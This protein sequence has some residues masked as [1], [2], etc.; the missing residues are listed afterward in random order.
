MAAPKQPSSMTKAIKSWT[1]ELVSDI[2]KPPT[3]RH[4]VAQAASSSSSSNSTNALGAP[5]W[6]D[7][8]PGKM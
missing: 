5:Y 4:D 2:G 1:K 3:H 7:N 6:A 8:R